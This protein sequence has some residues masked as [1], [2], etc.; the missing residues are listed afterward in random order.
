MAE[1][2]LP[3]SMEDFQKEKDTNTKLDMLF[4]FQTYTDQASK[5]HFKVHCG[6]LEGHDTDIEKLKKGKVR[7]A[8]R[9]TGGAAGG[10]GIIMALKWIFGS[11]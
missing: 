10:G 4:R 7:D 9:I 2:L 6:R 3:V 1:L 8:F 5:E 11:S